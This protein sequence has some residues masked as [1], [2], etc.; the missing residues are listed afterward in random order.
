MR[1]PRPQR[2][3]LT[4]AQGNKGRGGEIRVR[5]GEELRFVPDIRTQFDSL[6]LC[7]GLWA[8]KGQGKGLLVL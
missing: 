7:G 5:P 4:E 1:E 3:C 8:P 6:G 2:L